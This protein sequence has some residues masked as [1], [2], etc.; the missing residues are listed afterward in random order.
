MSDVPNQRL[1]DPTIQQGNL[2]QIAFVVDIVGTVSVWI[3][4]LVGFLIVMVSIS[5]NALHGLYAVNPKYWDRVDEVKKANFSV[6][7]QSGGNKVA[8]IMGTIV[9]A[10]LLINPNIKALTEFDDMVIDPKQ[11]FLKAIPVMVLQI[12]IGVFIFFGYPAAI[13]EKMADFGR[14]ML[15]LAI[16][17]IDPTAWVQSLPDKLVVLNLATDDSVIDSDK[18]ANEITRACAKMVFT[19]LPD[20]TKEQ[21]NLVALKL[22]DWVL[23]NMKE[24]DEYT[25]MDKYDMAVKAMCRPD[26][27]DLARVHNKKDDDGKVITFAW[28]KQLNEL[29]TGSADV[30]EATWWLQYQLT[31]TKKATTGKTTS[32]SAIMYAPELTFS[33]KT[34]SF[35]FPAE[36]SASLFTSGTQG[37]IAI[38][39]VDCEIDISGN[40]VTFKS[41]TSKD[42]PTGKDGTNITGFGYKDPN[43]KTHPIV[44]IKF[45][46]S[47]ITFKPAS[48]NSGISGWSFGDSPKSKD[49]GGEEGD[50]GNEEDNG[51]DNNGEEDDGGDVI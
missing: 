33:G 23:S 2:N 17:N 29:A 14:G 28:K 44:E 43:G 24:C 49:S 19:T 5:K 21:R 18:E 4:S 27:P 51:E 30:K 31:F 20:T 32:V 9:T 35:E 7:S 41:R 22:E 13:A 15:D 42:I 40:T 38:G 12:F 3:I 39:D 26:E 37:R 8:K 50:S 36:S 1:F 11:Y 46:N 48:E 25:N 10:W 45:G 6:E 16:G 34:A 47:D